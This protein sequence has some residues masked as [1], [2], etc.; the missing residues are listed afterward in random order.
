MQLKNLAIATMAVFTCSTT[1]AQS[2]SESFD[3]LPAQQ[4]SP[5]NPLVLNHFRVEL[6][7]GGVAVVR[8]AEQDDELTSGMVLG[9]HEDWTLANLMLHFDQPWSRITFSLV[10]PPTSETN[11]RSLFMLYG[12]DAGS[13][14]SNATL[15]WHGTDRRHVRVELLRNGSDEPFQRVML[16]LLR[17]AYVD[18]ISVDAPRDVFDMAN[19]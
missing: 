14:F 8:P 7:L 2:A 9:A 5:E 13:P 4:I 16:H 10:L 19:E 18:N 17:G 15:F 1:A 11:I 6:P 12:K 3:H